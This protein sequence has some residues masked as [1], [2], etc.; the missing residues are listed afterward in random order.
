MA[1]KVEVKLIDD[2]D[3]SE[4]SQTVLFGLDGREYEIDLNDA[5]TAALRDAL[6]PFLGAARK[7]SGG[8]VAVRRIGSTGPTRDLAKVR[9]WARENG[10]PDLSDRGRVPG[11]V[12]NAY[13][14]AA[15]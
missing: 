13:D 6:A 2:L 10:W 15:A 8:R 4:A 7:T 5:H 14:Q 9:T 1:Q 3:G 12:L 11:E